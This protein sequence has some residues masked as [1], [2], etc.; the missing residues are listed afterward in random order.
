M[1]SIQVNT[2]TLSH[3]YLYCPKLSLYTTLKRFG[4]VRKI[5]YD[6]HAKCKGSESRQ[7]ENRKSHWEEEG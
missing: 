1:S 6:F 4:N 5:S 2:S 3:I 7:V